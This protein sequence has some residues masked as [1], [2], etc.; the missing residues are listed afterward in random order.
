MSWKD[1]FR[2]GNQTQNG[3]HP[4]DEPST[5]NILPE[6]PSGNGFT[7]TD[8]KE[9]PD[10]THENYANDVGVGGVGSPANL[11]PEFA[12]GIIERLLRTKAHNSVFGGSTTEADLSGLRQVQATHPNYISSDPK[13]VDPERRWWHPNSPLIIAQSLGGGDITGLGSDPI[14]G[15][16]WLTSNAGLRADLDQLLEDA[17]TAYHRHRSVGGKLLW[18]SSFGGTEAFG[19]YAFAKL[20]RKIKVNYVIDVKLIPTKGELLPNSYA[21][22]ELWR[23]INEGP[24]P[25]HLTI[26]VQNTE[27]GVHKKTDPI[28][29]DSL[30]TITAA[31][32]NASEMD[33]NSILNTLWTYSCGVI[34]AYPTAIDTPM[35]V[36]SERPAIGEETFH[37]FRLPQQLGDRSLEIIL[38]RADELLARAPEALHTMVVTGYFPS[39]EEVR[40]LKMLMADK[41]PG[42]VIPV[43]NHMANP[44]A[45]NSML[46]YG[47]TDFVASLELAP[48]VFAPY[49][50][51]DLTFHRKG[52]TRE[53]F[54]GEM[55]PSQEELDKANQV[56]EMINQLLED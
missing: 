46:R 55:H 33:G 41:A 47:I 38:Q 21:R 45:K 52:L 36:G 43:V 6:V 39:F 12:K 40:Y 44:H 54:L 28:L 24:K 13:G 25:N 5:R 26:V 8:L 53:E 14:K 17:A 27:R 48:S 42:R 19:K 37:D 34:E 3:A 22:G 10:P 15:A 30:T 18:V 9:W 4:I 23:F 29:A 56:Q 32:D 11:L 20:L 16:R 50:L 7:P 49:R 31:A 1:F 51:T 35:A 2:D